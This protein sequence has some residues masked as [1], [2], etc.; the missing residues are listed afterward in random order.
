MQF[1][2]SHI[3]FWDLSNNINSWV[4]RS[5]EPQLQKNY[6]PGDLKKVFD[7]SIYGVV[8]VEAHDSAVSTLV[9]IEWLSK[10]MQSI[11]EVK[12]SH[13]AF[14]DITA[15]YEKFI[16]DIEQIKKYKQVSG[17]R[18][19]LSHNPRLGYNPCNE[20]LSL[21]LNIERNLKYL[22]EKQL[23][24]NCQAYPYQVNN[25]LP[26]IIASEVTCVIDHLVLPGWNRVND[27]DHQMWKTIILELAKLDRV[28]IKASGIDMFR[29]YEEF[30]LV[31]EYFFDK[32]PINKIMYGSNYPVSFNQA[33]NYWYR[34]L[35]Q[36]NNLTQEDK[37]QIF[38]ENSQRVF[39]D[40]RL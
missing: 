26:A 21:N 14:A 40:N 22:A 38:F 25:L 33:P 23:I 12:Y 24:F 11:P 37:K 8:H 7:E 30:D 36:M 2:D 31:M 4:L 5:N 15:N 13:I 27:M 29:K 39:F 19:I 10:I 34:Y 1:I 20:D 6:M 32:F 18:H 9:E 28:F 17:I 35:D 3:H 16:N